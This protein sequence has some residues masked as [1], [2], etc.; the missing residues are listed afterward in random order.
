MSRVSIRHRPTRAISLHTWHG[1]F[2]ELDYF[3][4]QLDDEMVDCGNKLDFSKMVS[5]LIHGDIIDEH[6]KDLLLV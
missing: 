3:R 5:S 2:E 1:I 6:G 4:F